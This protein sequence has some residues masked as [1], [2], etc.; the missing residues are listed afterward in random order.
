[1]QKECNQ[2]NRYL[3]YAPNKRWR[4]KPDT[5]SLLEPAEIQD[6]SELK[7]KKPHYDREPLKWTVE[8]NAEKIRDL[9]EK[10]TERRKIDE[11]DDLAER[12]QEL[13]REYIDSRREDRLMIRKR[14]CVSV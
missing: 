1:M 5:V 4:E 6:K 10:L 8:E 3:P 12:A 14:R 9:F 7:I 11:M 13:I 2:V